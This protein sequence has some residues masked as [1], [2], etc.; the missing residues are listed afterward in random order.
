MF[1]RRKWKCA[2]FLTA[3]VMLA[4]TAALSFWRESR[5][6]MG[7]RILTQTQMSEYTDYVPGDFSW[8][9]R[10]NEERAAVDV[11]TS[12]IY[13]AQDIREGVQAKDLDGR[14]RI[15][16]A[17]YQIYFAPDPWFSDLNGAV[18][19]GHRFALIVTDGSRE[20]MQYDVVFT[21][22]PVLRLDGDP[23]RLDEEGRTVSEGEVCLWTPNDPDSGRYSVK[24]S[25]TEFHVRGETTSYMEKA[26]WKLSLKDKTGGNRDLAFLGMGADDDWIL[27]SLSLDDTKLKERL[28]MDL[29]N[30]MAAEMDGNWKMSA[31]EYVEVV[32]GGRYM[33]IYLLQRRLDAK[34][35]ELEAGDILLKGQSTSKAEQVSDA[36]EVV[37]SPLSGE[38]TCALAA[39][40][41]DR[42]DC[43]ILRIDNFVD[44]TLFLQYAAAQDNTRYK[45]MFYVLREGEAGYEMS[46]IPWDTDLSF[47]VV[48]NDGFD[49]DYAASLEMLVRRREYAAMEQLYPD[50]NQRL[51]ERWSQ[52]RE[53]VLSLEN[54]LSVLRNAEAPLVSSGA[55]LREWERWPPFYEG[56]DTVEN[57]YRIAEEKLLWMD[58]YYQPYLS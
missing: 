40:V 43:S 26:P 38:E 32:N 29:W 4:A 42:S 3:L 36:Y 49:Y 56:E 51:A 2:A 35:L 23:A 30:G 12:A 47:G 34:Y 55:S 57:L 18:E 10:Y 14:L 52:L 7:V 19:E 48:W 24:S 45:N 25:R 33:G 16:H 46:M 17:G 9:M 1:D 39:G 31:G 22:L 8:E 27:N 11:H 15:D 41:W 50:L 44:V 58:A 6:C 5:T 21:T 13:I 37:S 20:Y 28:F 54:V 53:D